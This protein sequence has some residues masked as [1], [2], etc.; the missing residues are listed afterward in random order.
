MIHLDTHLNSCATNPIENWQFYIY[1][2]IVDTLLD[3]IVFNDNT[4]GDTCFN[5]DP[6]CDLFSSTMSYDY[7]IWLTVTDSFGCIDST[8]QTATVLCQPIADFDSTYVCF[9][10][11][12]VFTNQSS[13]ILG[14]DWKWEIDPSLGSYVNS[15]DTSD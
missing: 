10:D 6:P 8:M 7:N 3:S 4:I 14:M 13:P 5:F 11:N 15:T 2:T 12:K 1:N 9:G